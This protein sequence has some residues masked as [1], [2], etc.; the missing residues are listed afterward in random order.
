MGS[1]VKI[2]ESVIIG[3]PIYVKMPTLKGTILWP[4]MYIL[5]SVMFVVQIKDKAFIHHPL[6]LGFYVKNN[7]RGFWVALKLKARYSSI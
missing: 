7:N 6:T 2:T 4:F 3:D 1:Y 5:D